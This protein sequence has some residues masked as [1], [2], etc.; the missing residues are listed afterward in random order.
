MIPYKLP[1]NLISHRQGL[2]NSILGA[3]APNIFCM[4]QCN[5]SFSYEV[6]SKIINVLECNKY[7]TYCKHRNSQQLHAT[8]ASH[9][10][11]TAI[12]QFPR[13][14]VFETTF[15]LVYQNTSNKKNKGI[16]VNVLDGGV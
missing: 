13:I 8:Q 12:Q 15:P 2:T 16:P 10:Q 4:K 9:I 14:N 7:I 3:L 5:N 1:Q 11:S 6:F